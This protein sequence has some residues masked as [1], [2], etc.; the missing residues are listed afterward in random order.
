VWRNHLCAV[1]GSL[2]CSVGV[3]TAA[4]R[5][6]TYDEM[7][8][9][10]AE[11]HG[12]PEALVHRIV[13]RESRYQPGLVH[14]HCFGLMQIKYATAREMGYNG[15]AIGLLDPKI[16]LTYAVPYLANAYRLADGDEDRA[17]TLFSSGYYYTAH[18][19]KML[20]TLRTASSPTVASEYLNPDMRLVVQDDIQQ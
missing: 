8:A 17:V 18:Q 7:I 6:K 16:N 11:I 20:A 19:K 5:P 15:D 10:Q 2:S 14:R 9:H 3:A 12:V 13:K 1:I 4:D